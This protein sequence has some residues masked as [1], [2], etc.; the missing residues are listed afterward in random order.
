MTEGVER[1][2]PRIRSLE[3]GD[4]AYCVGETAR[5]G[6]SSTPDDFAVH[7][8]HDPQGCFAAVVGGA[9][10]GMIT[11]T[12]YRATG[13]I[14][15]L[16]VAPG[17]RGKGIGTALMRR[18][19]DVLEARGLRTLRLEADPM[20]IAIYRGL[21]FRDEFDSPRFRLDAAP[22]G[23]PDP[24]APLGAADLDAVAR[25]DAVRFGDGRRPL[26]ALLLDRASAAWRVPARGRLAG[27]L[28]LLAGASGLR[29]GPW[30][31][32]RPE[33]ARDLLHSALRRAAGRT[34]TLAVPGGNPG[35]P[36]LLADAGFRLTP[37][38]LRMMR[39][40]GEGTGRPES[41]WA[42]A[43]GAVG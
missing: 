28:M 27:Y 37:S 38:S 19:I 33:A 8:A 36:G 39:G 10:V 40:A 42:L 30:V 11:T 5:E 12:A 34:V 15:N 17:Q 25:F 18:A 22:D 23:G 4:I 29:I 35:A 9:P 26:L 14:G 1:G 13:W 43:N 32:D 41:V 16:I 6:W 3:G 24:A 21:G 31:A 7:L 2:G 20:G